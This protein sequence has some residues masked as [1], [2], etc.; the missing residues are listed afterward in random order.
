MAWHQVVGMLPPR[1][2]LDA[3]A[4]NRDVLVLPR[5]VEPEFIR[6]IVEVGRQREIGDGGARAQHERAGRE[7]L[8]DNG[9]V[10][11]DAPLEE[12]EYGGIAR[13]LGEKPQ[14]A[15]GPEKAVDLLVVENDPTQRLETLVLA[16]GPELARPV[17]KVGQDHAGLAEL[18]VA[19]DE[20]GR[21]AHLV[22]IGAVLR[23]TLLPL[24]KEVDP[25]RLPVGANE[26]EHEGAAIGVAGLGEAVELIFGHY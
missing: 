22:D 14:K 2:R 26:I 19:V 5:N 15:I 9:E 10:V 1:Q 24:G 11:V 13:R 7:P 25:D 8:V 20:Y 6:R 3:V 16:I 12:R 4:P 17:G 21:L 18:L 23:R